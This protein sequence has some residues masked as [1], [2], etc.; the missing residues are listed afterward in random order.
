[1]S[2]KDNQRKKQLSFK[3]IF[4]FQMTF[5]TKNYLIILNKLHKTLVA[6]VNEINGQVILYHPYTII[7]HMY[8]STKN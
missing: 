2:L 3:I 8:I 4:L 5:A 1:M 6:N 7:C